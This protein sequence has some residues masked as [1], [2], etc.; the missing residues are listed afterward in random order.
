MVHCKQCK[1]VCSICSK[2]YSFSFAT[3]AKDNRNVTEMFLE[4]ATQ[5]INFKK[6]IQQMNNNNH[7]NVVPYGVR[8]TDSNCEIQ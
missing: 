7:R 4:S 1:M 5:A 6:E 2:F 8:V 3:S